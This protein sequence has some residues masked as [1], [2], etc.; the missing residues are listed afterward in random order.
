MPYQNGQPFGPI[1][2]NQLSHT[3]PS[4]RGYFLL[5][6]SKK[7]IIEYLWAR[8]QTPHHQQK[9]KKNKVSKSSHQNASIWSILSLVGGEGRLARLEQQQQR[10]RLRKQNRTVKE[11]PFFQSHPH[12]DTKGRKTKE[13]FY[14]SSCCGPR[15]S[16]NL[17]NNLPQFITRFSGFASFYFKKKLNNQSCCFH[18]LKGGK[19]A[20]EWKEDKKKH[21]SI[22]KGKPKT[23]GKSGLTKALLRQSIPFS[24]KDR[25]VQ[26]VH[27]ALIGTE[28]FRCFRIT[29]N[30]C[31]IWFANTHT[32]TRALLH[33]FC[34]R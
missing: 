10:P 32:Q 17:N 20:Q 9:Q 26:G 7:S 33:F 4:P 28:L 14:F 15:C 13:S 8:T 5:V 16:F 19:L 24:E 22:T 29:L 2:G 27:L 21:P 3:L 1:C 12:K 6:N 18:L 11:N 34:L 23:R 31:P 30:P 25:R